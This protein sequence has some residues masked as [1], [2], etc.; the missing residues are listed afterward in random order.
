MSD[1]PNSPYLDKARSKDEYIA[2]IAIEALRAIVNMGH[3]QTVV[4]HAKATLRRIKQ[5]QDA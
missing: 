4:D 3:E 2:D 5:V 1:L